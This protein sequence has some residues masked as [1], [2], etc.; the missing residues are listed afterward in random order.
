MRHKVPVIRDKVCNGCNWNPVLIQYVDAVL[1]EIYY[2][3]S[4][5]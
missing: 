4:V 2:N 5:L 1:H 3:Y